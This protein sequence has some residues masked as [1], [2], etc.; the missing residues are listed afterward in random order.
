MD[1]QSHLLS[2]SSTDLCLNTINLN[3]IT[4]YTLDQNHRLLNCSDTI[5]LS[6]QKVFKNCLISLAASELAMKRKSGEVI[7]IGD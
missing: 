3:L 1:P 7:T 4:T 2:K 6:S 5:G